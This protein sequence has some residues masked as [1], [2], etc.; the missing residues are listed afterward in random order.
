MHRGR[1]RE[2]LAWLLVV[3]LLEDAIM[4]IKDDEER[5]E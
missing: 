2:R 3:L 4:P 5:I 1:R